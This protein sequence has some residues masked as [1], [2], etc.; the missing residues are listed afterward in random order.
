MQLS[1]FNYL[2]NLFGYPTEEFI[3]P[4]NLREIGTDNESSHH[5]TPL[6]SKI[7][8]S[9]SRQLVLIKEVFL[10]KQSAL[11]KKSVFIDDK[12]LCINAGVMNPYKNNENLRYP[13][14]G[15][16]IALLDENGK[17]L[18]IKEK[19]VNIYQLKNRN[20]F[21]YELETSTVF[22]MLNSID[23]KAFAYVILNDHDILV[24]PFSK[25]PEAL[26]FEKELSN[27]EADIIIPI[28]KIV[29]F[30]FTATPVNN[31]TE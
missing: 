24:T 9:P 18:G 27:R 11:L 16:F 10:E 1:T 20:G 2:I 17:D 29:S 23:G 3:R 30:E 6:T 21:V 28:S 13:H 14:I 12:K 5:F 7:K 8:F 26:Y 25:H 4:L 31:R 19:I 15:D 22:D